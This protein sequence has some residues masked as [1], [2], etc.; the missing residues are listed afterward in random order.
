MARP[1]LV[2]TFSWIMH[3]IASLLVALAPLL[4]LAALPVFTIALRTRP[5]LWFGIVGW[6]LLL[7]CAYTALT[8]NPHGRHFDSIDH[9]LLT[10]IPTTLVLVATTYTL[11][12]SSVL[13]WHALRRKRA[14]AAAP[15]SLPW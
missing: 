2:S 3:N 15:S 12:I 13:L 6:L 4:L 1:P 9:G 5:F 10:G 8:D 11:V 14:P 7:A